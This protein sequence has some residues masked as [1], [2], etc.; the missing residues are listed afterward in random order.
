GRAGGKGGGLDG[1]GQGV[2]GGDRGG[3][4]EVGRRKSLGSRRRRVA[5][6]AGIGDDQR[7]VESAVVVRREGEARVRPCCERGGHS[8]PGEDDGPR[9]RRGGGIR[10]VRVKRDNGSLRPGQQRRGGKRAPPTGADPALR[11]PA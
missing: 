2:P 7:H 11:P 8:V 3:R 9:V 10:D 6:R 5:G 4:G 1:V